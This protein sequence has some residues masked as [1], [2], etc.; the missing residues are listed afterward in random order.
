MLYM[1]GGGVLRGEVRMGASR[2]ALPVKVFG[3]Q[4]SGSQQRKPFRMR[5][6]QSA[7]VCHT[8]QHSDSGD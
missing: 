6:S 8:T 4:N 5:N 7:I 2:C 3:A 1:Q